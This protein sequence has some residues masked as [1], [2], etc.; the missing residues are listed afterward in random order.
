MGWPR[1]SGNGVRYLDRFSA[2]GPLMCSY[3]FIL[4]FMYMYRFGSSAVD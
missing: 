3:R 1:I 2:Y 4:I